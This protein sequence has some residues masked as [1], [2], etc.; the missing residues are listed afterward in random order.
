MAKSWR[1]HT[2]NQVCHPRAI[3]EPPPATLED[4]VALVK[5]AERDGTRVRVDGA[6]HSWSD[7]ALTDGAA[8]GAAVALR[9]LLPLDDGCLPR[10]DGAPPL[11]RVLA[12]TPL[13]QLNPAL[14][15]KASSLPN[16]G[17]YD[18]QTLAGVVSTSTHGSGIAFGPFPDLVES[19]D[20][21]IAG[22][23]IVRVEPEDGITDPDAFAARSR[24]RPTR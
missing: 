20:V 5:R 23:E 10:E 1:N 19:L 18:A 9:G 11:A 15:T 21:V 12:G 2:G 14:W 8:R 13:R 4:L 17:G 24:R 22:G 7:V 6:H 16:A 3:V